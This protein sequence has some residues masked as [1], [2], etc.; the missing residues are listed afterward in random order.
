MKN[1]PAMSLGVEAREGQRAGRS[2][3][4]WQLAPSL[5]RYALLI[6]SA[7]GLDHVLHRLGLY[8]VG[9]YLGIVGAALILLS[10]T[11]SLRKRKRI[12]L[13]SPKTLLDL[14]E[15]L[16]W[17][18]ALMILTHAGVHYNAVLPWAGVLLMLVV[19]ASGFVGKNLLREAREALKYREKVLLGQ[20]LGT[21][22]V[23]K[24]LLLDAAAVGAMQ[25][26]RSVHVPL[27]VTF[28]TLALLHIVSI[29]IFWRW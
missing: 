21:A 28:G 8:W 11:Y 7:V 3:L 13:G 20:G 9:R 24:R 14:H 5:F 26:W 29:L 16:S 2:L 27:T 4:L 6:A 15:Y 25:R 19:V 22:E 12:A 18:G 23:E 10:F 1:V 17:A